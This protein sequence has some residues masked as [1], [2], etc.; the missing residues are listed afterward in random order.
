MEP[1]NYSIVMRLLKAEMAAR[2]QKT[3]F[4][5]D[6]AIYLRHLVSICEEMERTRPGGEGWITD[7]AEY[8][9]KTK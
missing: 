8:G 1:T 5:S 7:T 9:Q 4:Q 3:N 2:L 6:D